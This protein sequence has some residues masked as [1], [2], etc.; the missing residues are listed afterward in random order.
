MPSFRW[1]SQEADSKNIKMFTRWEHLQSSLFLLWRFGAVCKRRFV[2]Q[3]SVRQRPYGVVTCVSEHW[4]HSSIFKTFNWFY[5]VSMVEWS[6]FVATSKSDVFR[7][8]SGFFST[9]QYS[10]TDGFCPVSLYRYFDVWAKHILCLFVSLF[11]TGAQWSHLIFVQ[12]RIHI[13]FSFCP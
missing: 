6:S 9:E 1:W 2:R 3:L 13:R 10:S 7:F 11:C 12:S 4:A 5:I 8:T